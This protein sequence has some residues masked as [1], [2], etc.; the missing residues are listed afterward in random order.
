MIKTNISDGRSVW[1]VNINMDYHYLVELNDLVNLYLC[2]TNKHG[3][4][5]LVVSTSWSYLIHDLLPG[6]LLEQHYSIVP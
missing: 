5:P 3:Y 6:M 4:I 2:V 1:N